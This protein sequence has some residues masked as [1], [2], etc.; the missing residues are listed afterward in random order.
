MHGVLAL[1]VSRILVLVSLFGLA[2]CATTFPELQKFDRVV[3]RDNHDKPL[4]EISNAA[5]I[6]SIRRFINTRRSG[7][8]VP[9]AGVPV[10]TLIANL[11]AGE[12]FIGHF[13]AGANFFECQREGGFY[14]RTANADELREFRKLVE[15][16]E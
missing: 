11:Y 6:E 9:L 8:Q 1:T 13:G 10:P 5:R 16:R 15:V 3:L 7:W 14:S 2:R 4:G 12:Q